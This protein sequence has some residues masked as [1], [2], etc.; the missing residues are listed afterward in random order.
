[1]SAEQRDLAIRDFLDDLSIYVAAKIE[2]ER[3]WEREN[4][5]ER[6]VQQRL[7]DARREMTESLRRLLEEKA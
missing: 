2:A 5:Y 6:G 7:D 1:M 4:Y 3:Q